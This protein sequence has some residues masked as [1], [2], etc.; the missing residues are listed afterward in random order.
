[1]GGGESNGRWGGGT[2]TAQQ[3]VDV[4][5]MTGTGG[6]DGGGRRADDWPTWGTWRLDV[7][8]AREMEADLG[9]AGGGD[10]GLEMGWGGCMVEGL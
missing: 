3:N 1:M 2:E 8:D 4:G 10:A 5:G 9:R 6:G 7:G